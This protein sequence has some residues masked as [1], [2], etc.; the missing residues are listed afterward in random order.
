MLKTGVCGEYGLNF[1]TWINCLTCP[2]MSK[3]CE[4]KALKGP[5]E[6]TTISDTKIINLTPS[7]INA[8]FWSNGKKE[9]YYFVMNVL[10]IL[11]DSF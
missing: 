3:A 7:Y 6:R 9:G 8:I 5:Y 10:Q 2:I 1:C 4:I 11:Y